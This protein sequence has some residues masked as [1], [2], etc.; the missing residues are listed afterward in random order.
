M[1]VGKGVT[2]GILPMRVL[3]MANNVLATINDIMAAKT[4]IP[5]IDAMSLGFILYP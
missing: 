1:L 2:S 4:P 5:A 3:G